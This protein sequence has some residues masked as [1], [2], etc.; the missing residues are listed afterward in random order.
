MLRVSWL[1]A[2]VLG[3]GIFAGLLVSTGGQRTVRDQLLAGV[4][5][6]EEVIDTSDKALTA[7]DE[8][9]KAQAALLRGFPEVAGTALELRTAT[10]DLGSIATSLERLG[11]ILTDAD[12]PLAGVLD[13]GNRADG[14]TGGARDEVA[15]VVGVLDR[16]QSKLREMLGLLDETVA[17]VTRIEAKLRTARA[18]PASAP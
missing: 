10:R 6:A 12:P 7:T 17:R 11:R 9:P 5:E 13:A 1:V 18:V 2:L 14:A 8:L 16:A 4:A 3:I 15:D